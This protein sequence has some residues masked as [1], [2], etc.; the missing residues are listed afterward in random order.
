M[1]EL[2]RRDEEGS[3]DRGKV[4]LV[5]G[6]MVVLGVVRGGSGVEEAGAFPFPSLHGLD[7]ERSCDGD[8]DQVTAMAVVRK[9]R[10]K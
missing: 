7:D 4:E 10:E 5:D 1:Q 6:K 8:E 3:D 2:G 9:F